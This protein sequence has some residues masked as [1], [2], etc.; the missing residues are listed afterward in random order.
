MDLFLKLAYQGLVTF[1]QEV[2]TADIE[3]EALVAQGASAKVYKAK[4]KGKVVALKRFNVNYV[5][6]SE[7]EF[8]RELAITCILENESLLQVSFVNIYLSSHTF[9]F[10][11][12]LCL[13]FWGLHSFA[14]R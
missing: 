3:V 5:G 2:D 4:Y 13:V 12:C 10:F 7:E 11:F 1:H 14:K 8:R 9:F 6:F